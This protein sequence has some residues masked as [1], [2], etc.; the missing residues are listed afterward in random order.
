MWSAVLMASL[1]AVLPAG[2]GSAAEGGPISAGMS[3][4]QVAAVLGAPDRIAVVDGKYLRD[5]T[6]GALLAA[7]PHERFVYIYRE[8]GMNGW[9][10][11]GRVSGA[12][13]TGGQPGAAAGN[14]TVRVGPE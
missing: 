10:V 8:Q 5:S 13:R 12:E 3:P 14:P 2:G 4:Q 6:E 7:R 1:M 9:F 11:D